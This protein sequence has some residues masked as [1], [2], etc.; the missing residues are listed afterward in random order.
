MAQEVGVFHGLPIMGTL[1]SPGRYSPTDNG[2]P[3]QPQQHYPS[4]TTQ[5]SPPT[6]TDDQVGPLNGSRTP[7]HADSPRKAGTFVAE[8][9]PRPSKSPYMELDALQHGCAAAFQ[10]ELRLEDQTHE[11]DHYSDDL[12]HRIKDMWP[13]Q[14]NDSDDSDTNYGTFQRR[15]SETEPGCRFSQPAQVSKKISDYEKLGSFSRDWMADPYNL[16]QQPFT[17][18]GLATKPSFDQSVYCQDRLDLVDQGQSFNNS[19]SYDSGMGDLDPPFDRGN[20]NYGPF[21]PTTAP[22]REYTESEDNVPITTLSSNTNLAFYE[23][24]PAMNQDR[25]DPVHFSEGDGDPEYKDDSWWRDQL[26]GDSP[27][28]MEAP[29]SKVDEPY[30]QL[31]YRAF[32]SR[33][34]KSMTL[35]D[36]YQWFRENTDKSKS[37]GKGWQNSIRH[38]LSMNGVCESCGLPPAQNHLT[39]PIFTPSVSGI[40]QTQFKDTIVRQ[41]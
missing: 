10:H 2:Y 5:A 9:I 15:A 39:N 38:N 12:Q 34:N 30:A 37:E 35:Q 4:C 18:S 17:W 20:S 11:Q 3:R 31:I 19:A 26:L 6:L 28:S 33:P 27:S 1:N 7:P 23:A 14:S 22:F 21:I 13:S 29:G 16:F 32:M 40:H 8:S 41:P 36:I 25:E 24:S